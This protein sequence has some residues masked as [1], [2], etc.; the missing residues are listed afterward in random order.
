MSCDLFPLCFPLFVCLPV[1]VLQHRKT[2]F[3]TFLQVGVQ[4]GLAALQ[5]RPSVL[6]FLILHVERGG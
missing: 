2:L 1:R 6:L 5:K 3:N 4:D